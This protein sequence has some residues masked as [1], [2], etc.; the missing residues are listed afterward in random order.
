MTVEP[1]TNTP[2]PRKRTAAALFFVLT[3]FVALGAG[4]RFWIGDRLE[5]QD[6]YRLSAAKIE[7]SEAPPWV[8]SDFVEGA[9]RSSG[10]DVSGSLLDSNLSQKLF[11]AFTAE[12]WVESVER[13]EIRF[14][15][16]AEVGLTYRRPVALVE[17][18]S[19]GLFPVDHNGV[20]LPTDYFINVAPEK[21]ADYPRIRGVRSMPLGTVGTP[22][23]DPL[24]HAAAQLAGEL[25]EV[26]HEAEIAQILPV[27]ENGRISCRL[28]TAGETDILWGPFDK[29]DPKN[30][31]KIEHLRQLVENDRSPDDVPNNFKPIDLT[32]E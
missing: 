12:P 8:S 16:G 14:P 30:I 15:S 23:G 13:V 22:W 21:K 25:G 11:Q 2:L 32:K 4:A 10:L 27:Q 1:E 24:V 6:V 19:R 26:V 5:E 29:A 18:P 28:R 17:L 31:D 7:V 20:L 9:L 3:V